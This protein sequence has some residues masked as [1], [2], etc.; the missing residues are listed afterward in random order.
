MTD[1]AVAERFSAL[2]DRTLAMRL[3][4]TRTLFHYSTTAFQRARHMGDIEA[5][6]AEL[7]RRGIPDSVT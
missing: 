6:R 5:L 1:T 7:A 3:S 2:S 4:T